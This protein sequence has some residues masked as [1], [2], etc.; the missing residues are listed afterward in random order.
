[1]QQQAEY[2]LTSQPIYALL[3]NNTYTDPGSLAPSLPNRANN[4]NM[5]TRRLSKYNNIYL[6]QVSNL[7][8]RGLK[9]VTTSFIDLVKESTKEHGQPVVTLF[10]FSGYGT[11]REEDADEAILCGTDFKPSLRGDAFRILPDYI[12]PLATVPGIHMLLMDCVQINFAYSFLMPSLPPRFHALYTNYCAC[13]D[14]GDATTLRSPMTLAWC[15]LSLQGYS[16]EELSK[17]VRIV[18]MG[19]STPIPVYECS[20]LHNH[21]VFK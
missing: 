12:E 4:E 13:K 20:T 1:M 21:F 5:M 9:T 15:E 10:Y 3:I 16:I 17:R 7:N 19:L 14:G 11:R 6:T 18:L 2:D 8:A